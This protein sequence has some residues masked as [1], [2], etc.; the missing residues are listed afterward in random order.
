MCYECSSAAV[1]RMLMISVLQ[2]LFFRENFGTDSVHGEFLLRV[3]TFVSVY[4]L[5]RIKKN[6]L[7]ISEELKYF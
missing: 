4:I 6:T 1:A 7:E 5:S 2:A 3:N